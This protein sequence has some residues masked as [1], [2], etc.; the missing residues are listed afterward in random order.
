MFLDKLVDSFVPE[1]SRL[2]EW[3]YRKNRLFVSVSFISSFYALLYLPPS[4]LEKYY[5]ASYIIIFFFT[6]NA[7][8]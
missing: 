2:E 4:L 5:G 3:S 7:W 1:A 8:N 6:C